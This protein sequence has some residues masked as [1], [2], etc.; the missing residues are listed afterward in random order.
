MNSPSDR[1]PRRLSIPDFGRPPH[2]WDDWYVLG[3]V[4]L[5]LSAVWVV[6]VHACSYLGGA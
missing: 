4:A 2:I 1:E 3:L 5:A 6:L